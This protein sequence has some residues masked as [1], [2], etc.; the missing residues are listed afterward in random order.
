MTKRH[1]AG[2]EQ[3]GSRRD[4]G[5]RAIVEGPWKEIKANPRIGDIA[6]EE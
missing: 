5:R 1:C 6:K 4:T 2:E 3:Q